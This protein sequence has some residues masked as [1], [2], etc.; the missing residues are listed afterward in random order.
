M[1]GNVKDQFI[2][3]M[4][5]QFEIN[6]SRIHFWE[7]A[8]Q[9]LK[10]DFQNTQRQHLQLQHANLMP[11]SNTLYKTKQQQT[12]HQNLISPK[13]LFWITSLRFEILSYS[14]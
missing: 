2:L 12:F 11:E 10:A 6:K 7:K 4:E 9:F 5:E 14:S 3:C 1:A 8:I 13:E